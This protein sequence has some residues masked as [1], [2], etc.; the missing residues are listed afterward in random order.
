V[1]PLRSKFDLSKRGAAVSEESAG[2]RKGLC[3]LPV[4]A[5][6]QLGMAA[7]QSPNSNGEGDIE[8]SLTVSEFEVLDRALGGM[9]GLLLG[10]LPLAIN[11]PPTEFPPWLV[12]AVVIGSLT[13]MG[14]VSAAG[15]L[16][17]AKRAKSR[18]VLGDTVDPDSGAIESPGG[19]DARRRR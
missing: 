16:A 12:A 2:W 1:R 15:S 17:L 11:K 14:A 6:L 10:L 13:L 5:Q 19:G 3:D 18:E 7:I 4:R 9:V 8:G